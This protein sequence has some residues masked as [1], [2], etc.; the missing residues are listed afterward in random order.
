VS[1]DDDAALPQ[2]EL[3]GE[4]LHFERLASWY[5]AVGGVPMS[6]RDSVRGRVIVRRAG[7]HDTL[8]LAVPVRRRRSPRER[9]R[10]A[11]RF[12]APPDSVLPRIRAE[13]ELVRRLKR[14]AH[15][16]ARLWQAPFQRPKPGAITDPFGME[17]VFNGKLESRHLGVD[18]QG[19]IGDPVRASNRGIVMYAGPLYYSGN[20]I[21]LDHGDGVVT[22]YLHLSKELV[23]VGD[24]VDRGQVIGKVGAT[25]RVTGPHLHWLAAYG[26][27]TVDPFDLLSLDLEAPLGASRSP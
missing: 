1:S 18:F 16:T 19:V 9:L 23:A 10:T 2:G 5:R 26:S 25:G 24:T 6:A 8:K 3:A 4:P 11:P 22:A 15:A 20:T 17:R 21:F 7:R 27:V 14:H 12:V 13:R